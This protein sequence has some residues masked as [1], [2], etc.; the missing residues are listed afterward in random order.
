MDIKCVCVCACACVC[1][2]VRACVRA[3]VVRLLLLLSTDILRGIQTVYTCTYI[4]V[5]HF[6]CPC[7]ADEA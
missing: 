7:V 1:V 2:C 5:L 3:C 6:S 4:P